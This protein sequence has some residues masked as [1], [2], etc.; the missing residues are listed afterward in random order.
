MPDSQPPPPP[1]GLIAAL[2]GVLGLAT[3]AALF[4]GLRTGLGIFPALAGLSAWALVVALAA[5]L[6]RLRWGLRGAFCALGTV[7]AA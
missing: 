2:A 4:L 5:L 1:R 3:A 6:P 7:A